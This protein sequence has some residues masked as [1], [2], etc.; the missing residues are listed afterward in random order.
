[1]AFYRRPPL[2]ILQVVWPNRDG[3][4]PWQPGTDLPFR[5]AQP[6]LWLDPKQHPAGV[7]TRRL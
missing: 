4:F 3:L 6:W 1:M 7:W 2:P 5:H